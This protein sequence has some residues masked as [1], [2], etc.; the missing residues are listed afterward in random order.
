MGWVATELPLLG[1]FLLPCLNKKPFS[2]LMESP[3]VGKKLSPK[4]QAKPPKDYRAQKG[5]KPKRHCPKYWPLLAHLV[6]EALLL[7]LP[8][9]VQESSQ[10]WVEAPLALAGLPPHIASVA[11]RQLHTA[12]WAMRLFEGPRVSALLSQGISL[13]GWR[14]RLHSTPSTE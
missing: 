10:Q 13:R 12:A 11:T 6:L 7:L 14:P 2:G 5:V 1:C 9:R 3:L 4:I 8:L